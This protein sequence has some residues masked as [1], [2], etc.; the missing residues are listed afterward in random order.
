MVHPKW[1]HHVPRVVGQQYR[2]LRTF[3]K[4][5]PYNRAGRYQRNTTTS[6][7]LGLKLTLRHNIICLKIIRHN[8]LWHLL[9][10]CLLLLLRLIKHRLLL[11]P[12]ISLKS[13][14][15]LIRLCWIN[16]LGG[17]I[18]LWLWTWRPYVP[19]SPRLWNIRVFN[20][21][22]LSIAICHS[23]LPLR[24]LPSLIRRSCT[25]SSPAIYV[26]KQ[27]KNNINT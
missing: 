13:L 20:L 1:D 2:G 10:L 23:R 18:H 8:I 24:T 22:L 19:T 9:I 5:R 14:C 7:S 25:S 15:I 27:I 6:P 26:Q 21:E 11:H 16:H 12:I 4:G 3:G 17:V